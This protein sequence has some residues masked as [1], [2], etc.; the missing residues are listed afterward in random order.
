MGITFPTSTV[1]A[2]SPQFLCADSAAHKILQDASAILRPMLDR[3]KIFLGPGSGR[4]QAGRR[5]VIDVYTSVTGRDILSLSGHIHEAR[6]SNFVL[7]VHHSSLSPISFS[8]VPVVLTPNIRHGEERCD[9]VSTPFEVLFTET[10]NK[11]EYVATFSNLAP[12][13]YT[14]KIGDPNVNIYGHERK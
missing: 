8:G 9:R 14:V 10:E 2:L 5:T 13:N 6:K 1:G 11:D 12:G 4:K 3:T 7:R